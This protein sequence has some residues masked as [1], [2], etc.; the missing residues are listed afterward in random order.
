MTT[1]WMGME[2]WACESIQ[3]LDF[4][5]QKLLKLNSLGQRNEKESSVLLSL[6]GRRTCS[7]KK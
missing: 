2:D 3:V 1:K 7:T 4:E 6:E 5:Q